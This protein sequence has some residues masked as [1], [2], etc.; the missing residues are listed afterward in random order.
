MNPDGVVTSRPVLVLCSSRSGSTLL[1]YILNSHPDA[2]CPPELHF[3]PAANRMINVYANTIFLDAAP[4][5]QERVE[6]AVDRVSKHFSA[7]MRE[8]CEMNGA[9]VWCEK[10]VSSADMISLIH[11]MF[12][13]GRYVCLYRGALDQ[14]NSGLDALEINPDGNAFGYTPYLERTRPNTYNGLVDYWLDKNTMISDFE[15]EHEDICFRIRY[16]DI[17]LDTESTIRRLFNFIGLR[18]VD[19][20]VANIFSADHHDGPG[21]WKIRQTNSIVSTS[22]GRFDPG[23]VYKLDGDRVDKIDALNKILGYE[24]VAR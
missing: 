15:R 11:R 12:P 1:R 13:H 4:T 10:S 20:F 14:L 24:P 16:E 23:L 6:L 22:V 2:V 17:V 21:D 8:Y 5:V 3:V 7:I 19:D 9:T 18:W